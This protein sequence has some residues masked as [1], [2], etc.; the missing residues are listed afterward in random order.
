MSRAITVQFIFTY[1]RNQIYG[2]YQ[3]SLP[4]SERKKNIYFV[5]VAFINSLYKIRKRLSIY[6]NRTIFN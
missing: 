6:F 1:K 2:V 4:Y 3:I 5:N